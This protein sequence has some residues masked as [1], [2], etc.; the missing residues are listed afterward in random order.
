MLNHGVQLSWDDVLEQ[1]N[2]IQTLLMQSE[3]F[4]EGIR[5]FYEKR[6]PQFK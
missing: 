4:E 6:A 3:D 1:E 2:M 5:A